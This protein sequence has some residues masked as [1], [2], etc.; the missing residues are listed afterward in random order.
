MFDVLVWAPTYSR[1]L[2]CGALYGNESYYFNRY[3]ESRLNLC[4]S[5]SWQYY[6]VLDAL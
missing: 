2:R 4:Y 6:N 1:C 3:Q 5:I